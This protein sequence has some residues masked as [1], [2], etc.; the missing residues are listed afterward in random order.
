M[1]LESHHHFQRKGLAN[2]YF[3]ID[4]WFNSHHAGCFREFYTGWLTHWGEKIAETGAA[5]TATAL[6]KILER[7]GSAVLYVCIQIP[8]IVAIK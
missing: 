7:N 4:Q 2:N 1:P 6:E 3:Y 5:F 8:T